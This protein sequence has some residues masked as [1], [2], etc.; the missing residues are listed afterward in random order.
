MALPW[1]RDGVRKAL[2]FDPYPGTLNVALRDREMIDA[3]RRIRQGPA[4]QLEP[5][6]TEACGAR[7][8]RMLVV[9]D[10]DVA[11]IVPDLTHYADDLLELVAPASLRESLGLRD[12]DRVVL[13]PRPA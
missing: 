6:A 4:L 10:V 9:P 12:D 11:V 13:E 5:P 3:W 1:V 8:Y 2:G 7:L